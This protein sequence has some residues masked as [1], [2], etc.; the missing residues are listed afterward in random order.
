MQSSTGSVAESRRIISGEDT[1]TPH[2]IAPHPT[3]GWRPIARGALRAKGRGS[4]R[5]VQ[6][7]PLQMCGLAPMRCGLGGD[8]GMNGT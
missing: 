8:E 2:H 1:D 6:I 5:N 7:W 4:Q 3:K